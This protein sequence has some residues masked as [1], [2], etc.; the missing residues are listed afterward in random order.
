MQDQLD[1]VLTPA[2]AAS[3][4]P[5]EVQLILSAIDSGQHP[6]WER[7]AR[8]R[9]PF[10]SEAE[11]R[12]FSDLND[13]QPRVLFTRDVSSRGLGFITADQLPLGHGGRV[14]VVLPSGRQLQIP[15]TLSRCRQINAGWYEGALHFNRE[16]LDFAELGA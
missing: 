14:Q 7:R 3:N 5:R 1:A 10:H 2:L 13:A 8:N 9:A 15:C 16:Q 4:L 6:G 12:L 11:L